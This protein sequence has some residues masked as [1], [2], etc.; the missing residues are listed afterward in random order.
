[1]NSLAADELDRY[2]RQNSYFHPAELRS[3]LHPAVLDRL[4][5]GD[6][7]LSP[8]GG[9]TRFFRSDTLDL[10]KKMM[11]SDFHH[12]LADDILVKVD[13]ASMLASLESRAP[14]LDHRLIEF[15]F[16]LPSSWKIQP[17]RGKIILRD[18]LSQL[19]PAEILTRSKRGFSIP[20]RKW[21]SDNYF[22]DWEAVMM[23]SRTRRYFDDR[24]LQ[25]YIREYRN[26]ERDHSAKI[27]LMLAFALWLHNQT[28][29]VDEVGTVAV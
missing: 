26:R 12:Y 5:D 8:A 4:R 10:S 17:G 16:S 27:W 15:A 20:L 6:I 2:I 23:D 29:A 1:M 19:L 18:S 21:L 14:F 3:L 9:R 24:V 13:R 25:R 22:C 7:P 11:L 28:S